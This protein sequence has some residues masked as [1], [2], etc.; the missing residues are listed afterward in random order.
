MK[1]ELDSLT[2]LY[3]GMLDIS[4]GFAFIAIFGETAKKSR[5]KS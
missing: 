3:L 1:I 5:K 2:V 4:L